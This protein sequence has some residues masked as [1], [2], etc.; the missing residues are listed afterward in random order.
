VTRSG[1]TRANEEMRQ[2]GA[3]FDTTVGVQ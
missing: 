3:C 2:A 1:G